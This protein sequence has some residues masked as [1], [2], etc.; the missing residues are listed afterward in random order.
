M[1]RAVPLTA[2]QRVWGTLVEVWEHTREGEHVY[3]N[4]WLTDLEVDTENVGAIVWIGRS[5]WKIEHEQFNV[6]KN[7][8]YPAPPWL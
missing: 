5:R 1:A 2:S 6:H 3:H 4:A 8:N 7:R